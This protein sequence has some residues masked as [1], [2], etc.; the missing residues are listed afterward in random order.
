MRL[1]SVFVALGCALTVAACDDDTTPTMS[2]MAVAL[3]LA[4]GAGPS[5]TDYCNKVQMNCTGSGDD[6]GSGNAQYASTSACVSYCTS[7]AGWPAGT[8][9]AQSGNT[10]ACR[11]YHAGAAAADPVFHCPH[12]GPTGGNICGSWC[13]NYCQLAARNCTGANAV[14]PSNCMAQCAMFATNGHVNDTTGNT[15]Q[16]RLYHLGAAAT[17][18]T[19]HC[20]HA[21][22]VT[23][24]PSTPCQ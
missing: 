6:G 11:L 23:D 14:Y 16:C 17:D 7:A 4:N 15:V 13:E 5:C 22:S 19:L 1:S 8:T 10:I 20:P 18:P 2:D 12:A 3:D 9:G 21:L 24:N